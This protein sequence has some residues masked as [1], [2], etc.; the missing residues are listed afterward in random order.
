MFFQ[1]VCKTSL[2][3]SVGFLCVQSKKQ[4]HQDLLL[5]R[6]ND[7]QC[8]CSCPSHHQRN[9][10]WISAW[11]PQFAQKPCSHSWHNCPNPGVQEKRRRGK[12]NTVPNEAFILSSSEEFWHTRFPGY[13]LNWPWRK[14]TQ[15]VETETTTQQQ[16]GLKNWGELRNSNHRSNRARWTHRFLKGNWRTILHTSWNHRGFFQR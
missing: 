6:G 10:R 11:W 12:N 15:R 14:R 7:A 9:T 8:V 13:F 16:P 3:N 1:F 4:C 2:Q 5:L